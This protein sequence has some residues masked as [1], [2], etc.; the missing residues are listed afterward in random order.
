MMMMIVV[1]ALTI[2]LLCHQKQQNYFKI[3]KYCHIRF[4][5]LYDHVDD[6]YHAYFLTENMRFCNCSVF[7]CQMNLMYMTVDCT[8]H[9]L[10]VSACSKIQMY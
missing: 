7:T 1:M 5:Y 10:L 2:K 3:L 4:V 8:V 6:V 9:Q